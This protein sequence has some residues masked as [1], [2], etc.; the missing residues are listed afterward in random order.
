MN[1]L[2]A[3]AAWCGIVAVTVLAFVSTGIDPA[4]IGIVTVV[5]CIVATSMVGGGVCWLKGRRRAGVIGVL[6]PGLLPIARFSTL[7]HV[8]DSWAPTILADLAALAI[9]TA[10]AVIVG[11]A[12]WSNPRSDARRHV[13]G[14]LP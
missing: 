13:P 12:A 4:A 6:A 10:V 9:L 1:R 2:V 7:V 5:G 11:V 3:M 8:S 14:R